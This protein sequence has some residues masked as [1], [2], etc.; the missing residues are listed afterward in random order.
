MLRGETH[1]VGG[2]LELADY[3]AAGDGQAYPTRERSF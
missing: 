3:R 2:G 1:I